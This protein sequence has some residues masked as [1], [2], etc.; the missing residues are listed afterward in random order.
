MLPAQQCVALKSMEERACVFHRNTHFPTYLSKQQGRCLGYHSQG[1]SSKEIAIIMGLSPKTVEYYLGI[2]RQ[3]QGCH[4]S[5]G[6]IVSY[7]GPLA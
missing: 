4:S 7:A 3:Q 5:K 6:L 1:K 2:I